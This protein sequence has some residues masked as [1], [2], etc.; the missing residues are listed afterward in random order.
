MSVYIFGYNYDF[1]KY[2]FF[3]KIHYFWWKFWKEG[4]FGRKKDFEGRK[5]LEEGRFRR[6]KGGFERKN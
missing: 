4:G 3:G 2:I 1:E 6:K 5:I